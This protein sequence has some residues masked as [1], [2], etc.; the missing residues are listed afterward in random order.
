MSNDR[1]VEQVKGLLERIN[2]NTSV[3]RSE[4]RSDLREIRD[5]CNILIEALGHGTDEA[6]E[7]D[8]L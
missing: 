2:S 6:G 1:L 4:T 8:G 3:A 5:E 7:E